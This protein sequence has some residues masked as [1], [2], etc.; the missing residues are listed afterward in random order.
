MITPLYLKNQISNQ[1]LMHDILENLIEITL[2]APQNTIRVMQGILAEFTK[3]T[4]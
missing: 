4:V 3:P 1:M 2:H